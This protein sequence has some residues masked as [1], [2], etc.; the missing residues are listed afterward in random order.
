MAD[1]QNPSRINTFSVEEV[2]EIG[3]MKTAKQENLGHFSTKKVK[4]KSE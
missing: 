1:G 2:K 4:N 3:E